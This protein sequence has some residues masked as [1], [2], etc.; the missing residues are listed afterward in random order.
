MC[1]ATTGVLDALAG[2]PAGQA[3]DPDDPAV[4]PGF[5]SRGP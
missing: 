3:V 4:G 2:A 1:D 5:M